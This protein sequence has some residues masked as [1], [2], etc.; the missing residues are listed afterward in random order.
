MPTTIGD[1]F[2]RLVP[3]NHSRPTDSGYSKTKVDYHYVYEFVDLI[4]LP[5]AKIQLPIVIINA[6]VHTTVKPSLMLC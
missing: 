4:Q 5:N 1:L 2:G 6:L 3:V